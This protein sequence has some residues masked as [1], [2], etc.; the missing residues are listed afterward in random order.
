VSWLSWL[1]PAG[2]GYNVE[3]LQLLITIVVAAF[4]IVVVW[5]GVWIPLRRSVARGDLPYLWKGV[6]DYARA[7]HLEAETNS[8]LRVQE[9]ERKAREAANAGR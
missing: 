3:T 1:L 4:D 2:V 6:A 9:A 7:S 5:F 8:R